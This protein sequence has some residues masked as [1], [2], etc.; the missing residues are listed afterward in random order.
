[1]RGSMSLPERFCGDLALLRYDDVV[2]ENAAAMLLG[3]AVSDALETLVGRSSAFR[4][5]QELV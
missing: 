5:D 2:D 4:R 1:M 3:V